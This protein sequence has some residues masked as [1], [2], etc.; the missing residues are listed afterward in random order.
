MKKLLI[1]VFVLLALAA[2]SNNGDTAVTDAQI[3]QETYDAYT[4]EVANVFDADISDN[5]VDYYNDEDEQPTVPEPPADPVAEDPEQ[6]I[7]FDFAFSIFGVDYELGITP[8]SVIIENFTLSLTHHDMYRLI[9]PGGQSASTGFHWRDDELAIRMDINVRSTNHAD[10]YMPMNELPLSS[11]EFRARGTPWREHV[12]YTLPFGFRFHE[13]TI[14]D[15]I[16][17]IGEPTTLTDLSSFYMIVYRA[18]FGSLPRPRLE[19]YITD[20]VLTNLRLFQDN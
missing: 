12:D 10:D 6:E 13:T 11:V 20:G 1:M 2:C 14:E 15:I 9:R 18:P 3:T 4:G 7:E 8:L 5:A 17:T 19:M 16:A